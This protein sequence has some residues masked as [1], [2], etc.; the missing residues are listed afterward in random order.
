MSSVLDQLNARHGLPGRLHFVNGPG[1]LPVA[2][3]E[4]ANC[5][6]RI[7][8]HGGHLLDYQPAHC[9]QPV[10]WLSP[11]AHFHLDEAIRGGVP[12]CWPWFGAHA[13]HPDWPAHGFARILEWHIGETRILDDD[14][15]LISLRLNS[16]MQV[17]QEPV[18]LKNWPYSYTL[19]LDFILG[20][21]LEMRLTTHNQDTRPFTLTQALHTYLAVSDIEQVHVKGLDGCTYL[22]KPQGFAAF[23]QQGDLHFVGETDR[24]Y[25]DT[26]A[27]CQVFDPLYQRRLDVEKLEG[28]ASTV[29]W[30]P[31]SRAGRMGDLGLEAGR[32]MLCIETANAATDK[33]VVRPGS[34][35]TLACRI[36][37]HPW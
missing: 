15:S 34:S 16:A 22:D 37:A 2:I 14:R 26:T 21:S 17:A 11:L 20:D 12:V 5:R 25:L 9:Q 7:S 30:N 18:T 13:D 4:Q 19:Q 35:H 10:I 8:L 29:V 32:H 6:A 31:G 28:S 24:V 1:D 27:T 23:A 3:V 36:V 33:R